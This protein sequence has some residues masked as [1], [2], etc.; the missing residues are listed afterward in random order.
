MGGGGNN[1]LGLYQ[2]LEKLLG[3]VDWG[4]LGVVVQ[5][6]EIRNSRCDQTAVK[7]LA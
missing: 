5:K 6:T 4:I 1:I 7:T 2:S 3:H